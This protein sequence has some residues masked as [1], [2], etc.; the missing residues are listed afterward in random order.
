MYGNKIKRLGSSVEMSIKR[1]MDK[2]IIIIPS[3]EKHLL[4]PDLI[5]EF[6]WT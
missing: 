2:E 4:K 5:V 6:L 3:P 1:R